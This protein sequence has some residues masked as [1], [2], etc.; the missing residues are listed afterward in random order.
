MNFN[1]EKNKL[2]E[3]IYLFLCSHVLPKRLMLWC[4]IFVYGSDSEC[5]SDEYKSKYDF[6]VNK[7]NI[8]NM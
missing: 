6:W 4:F 3:K 5:P 1:Y 8:K 7:Y 2:I